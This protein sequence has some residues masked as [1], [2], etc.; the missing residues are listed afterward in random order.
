ML[1]K[2][3]SVDF[4]APMI[5]NIIVYKVFLHISNFSNFYNFEES[6]LF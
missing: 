5:Y 2:K 4:V 1:H 6:G 3:I